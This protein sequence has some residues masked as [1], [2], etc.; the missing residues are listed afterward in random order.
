MM[1]LLWVAVVREQEVLIIFG[2]IAIHPMRPLHPVLDQ[3]IPKLGK[4][5]PLL[6]VKPLSLLVLVEPLFQQKRGTMAGKMVTVEVLLPLVF[7]V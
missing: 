7:L 6:G 4:N 3:V 5:V 1:C 2:V